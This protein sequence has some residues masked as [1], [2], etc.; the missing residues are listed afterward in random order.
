MDRPYRD[1]TPAQSYF[2]DALRFLAALAVALHHALHHVDFEPYKQFSQAYHANLGWLGVA[3]FFL[4]SGFLIAHTAGRKANRGEYS[5]KTYFVERTVRIYLVYV[6]SIILAMITVAIFRGDLFQTPE[7]SLSMA[8]TNLFMLQGLE[9]FSDHQETFF[10]LLPSWS[11]PYE[12][13]FYMLFGLATLPL[14]NR[15]S[16]SV[17]AGLLALIVAYLCMRLE[18]ALQYGALWAAGAATAYLFQ[19]VRLRFAIALAICVVA[20]AAAELLRADASPQSGWLTNASLAVGFAAILFGLNLTTPLP[21]RSL[22]SV[23]AGYSYSLYLTHTIWIYAFREMFSPQIEALIG[24]LGRAAT[25]VVILIGVNFCA[26][27]FALGTEAHNDSM[28]RWLLSGGKIA[29]RAPGKGRLWFV[30]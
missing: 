5:F 4:L 23:L 2:C 8:L 24:S 26:W 14:S 16:F 22:T 25:A 20:F 30:R 28:R 27:L 6:P 15:K 12:Y 13:W 19:R 10:L 17:I 29:W 18:F 11:L 7:T 1:L 3:V 21:A 9:P